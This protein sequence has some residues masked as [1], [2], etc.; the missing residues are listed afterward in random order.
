[1]GQGVGFG[2]GQWGMHGAGDCGD[3]AQHSLSREY[4]R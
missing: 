2:E 4:P 1:V 3:N